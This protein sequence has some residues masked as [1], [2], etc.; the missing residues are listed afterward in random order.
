MHFFF[1]SELALYVYYL[2][3]MKMN[4]VIV[5]G[6]FISSHEHKQKKFNYIKI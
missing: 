4:L 6:R 1:F 2:I 3:K 5:I